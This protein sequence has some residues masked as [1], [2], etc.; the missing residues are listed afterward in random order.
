MLGDLNK[1]AEQ[2]KLTDYLREIFDEFDDLYLTSSPNG[3]LSARRGKGA[4]VFTGGQYYF[5]KNIDGS[6]AWKGALLNV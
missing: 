6:T 3:S 1:P 5:Y 4:I 2:K